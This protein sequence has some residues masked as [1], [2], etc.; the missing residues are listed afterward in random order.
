MVATIER[1]AHLI[2]SYLDRALTGLAMTQAEAYV[3]A[4]LHRRGPAS[5]GELHRE[6][7]HK[8]STLTS[9]LDRLENRGWVRREIN[10]ADRRSFVIQLTRPG[11]PAAREVTDVLDA[12]ERRVAAAVTPRDLAGLQAVSESLATA[13]LAE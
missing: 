4:Q 9:V 1:S 6:F 8:P 7:G 3:L 2:A 13:V 5:I 10:P 11:R 12:L